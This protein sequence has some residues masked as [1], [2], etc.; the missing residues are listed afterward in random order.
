MPRN[1]DRLRQRNAD[2]RKKFND[3]YVKEG[4][5]AEV[6]AQE[7]ADRFYLEPTTIMKIVQGQDEPASSQ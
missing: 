5:R 3:K 2:I 4:K 1:P 6:I 7:L